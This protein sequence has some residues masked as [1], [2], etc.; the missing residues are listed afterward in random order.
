MD[1]AG[2]QPQL[3]YRPPPFPGQAVAAQARFGAGLR[4]QFIAQPLDLGCNGLE[5]SGDGLSA[6]FAKNRESLSRQLESTIDFLCRCRVERRFQWLA[7]PGVEAA[8]YLRTQGGQ[9][10][11]DEVLAVK[12]HRPLSDY[13]TNRIGKRLESTDEVDQRADDVNSDAYFI[14]V[15]QSK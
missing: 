9:L 2:K 11:P 6:L 12:S 5:K 15:I 4:N 14:A 1:H 7:R 8:E 10:R 13:P 3:V